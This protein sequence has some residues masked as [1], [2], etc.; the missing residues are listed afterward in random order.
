VTTFKRIDEIDDFLSFMLVY[1][2][3]RFVPRHKMDLES[4]FENLN[5]GALAV[6]VDRWSSERVAVFLNLAQQSL[7]A[8]RNGDALGG[9][10][11]I[12]EMQGLIKR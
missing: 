5:R 11:L 2:P 6:L 8:Y 4:V 9:S 12:Q 10:N 3:D 1:C 7:A